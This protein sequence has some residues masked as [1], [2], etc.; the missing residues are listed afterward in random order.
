MKRKH[1]KYP[2]Y[3]PGQ[4]LS[5]QQLNMSFNYLNE[6]TH[7]ATQI[8]GGRGIIKGLDI[9]ISNDNILTIFPGQAIDALGRIIYLEEEIK[10]K[11]IYKAETTLDINQGQLLEE[12]KHVHINKD[13]ENCTFGL[14][15]DIQKSN[16][17][18]ACDEQ[19]DTE[20]IVL[21]PILIS[22]HLLEER[23]TSKDYIKPLKQLTRIN[24]KEVNDGDIKSYLYQVYKH[25]NEAIVNFLNIIF[26]QHIISLL[27]IPNNNYRRSTKA[28]KDAANRV[29]ALMNNK[30]N[31]AINWTFFIYLQLIQKAIN[32]LIEV[33]NDFTHIYY[34]NEN[35]PNYQSYIFLGAPNNNS[36]APFNRDTYI[37]HIQLTEKKERLQN[38][39]NRLI[40]LLVSYNEQEAHKNTMIVPTA[41]EN[42]LL[43]NKAI[44]VFCKLK[45]N[46]LP[47]I[48]NSC[49]VPNKQPID[50]R[51]Y[52]EDS[53][54][55]KEEHLHI[56]YGNNTYMLEIGKGT[57]IFA[58]KERIDYLIRT[59]NLPIR[60]Q[61]IDFYSVMDFEGG[62]GNKVNGQIT[63]V[64]DKNAVIALVHRDGDFLFPMEFISY[65]TFE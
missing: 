49:W 29:L 57:D 8:L 53:A 65:N 11:T 16:A 47:T 38:H 12:N 51:Y 45:T 28:F 33:Y 42:S 60:C 19:K 56:D 22:N 50:A 46:I 9:S 35:I 4:M 3:S 26:G 32:E 1:T 37:D 36:L 17:L 43:E 44:P 18:M 24:L 58:I 30:D 7:S 23:H 15:I 31:G 62:Y 54:S 63:N 10:T 59:Y 21:Y 41:P 14:Y 34:S 55:F 2:V 39:Y 61:I 27:N 13:I 64:F 5:S 20:Q 48:L 40:H 25:N 52:V 6:Q